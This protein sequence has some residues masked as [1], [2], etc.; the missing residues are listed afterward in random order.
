MD[1]FILNEFN[2]LNQQFERKMETIKLFSSSF[3]KEL[4]ILDLLYF[5]FIKRFLWPTRWLAQSL[6][7]KQK[8]SRFKLCYHVWCPATKI[9]FNEISSTFSISFNTSLFLFI[10]KQQTINFIL[11]FYIFSHY[12]EMYLDVVHL[13]QFTKDFGT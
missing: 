6:F 12:R 9:N 3:V 10:W 4:F 8:K 13:E 1:E 11:I 2:N 7:W 5:L